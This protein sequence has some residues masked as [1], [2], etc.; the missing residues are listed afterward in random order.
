MYEEFEKK[1]KPEAAPAKSEPAPVK[2]DKAGK[3]NEDDELKIPGDEEFAKMTPKQ[4]ARWVM[5][6]VKNL[7]GKTYDARSQ[8]RDSVAQEIRDAQK[9]HPLLK[10]SS[11]YRELVLA[12][13]ESASQKGAVLSLKEACEKVDAF[14]GK[15]QGDEKV[16]DDDKI[17]LKKAKAQVERGAGAPASPGE[18]KDSEDRRLESIFGTG[19]AKSPL[20][21][22]GI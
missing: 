9:D 10:A 20:G 8:M 5:D 16:S 4:F 11:E 1:Q 7:V 18:D 2:E 3:E 15:G 6:N 19:G 22:L 17:R 14:A 12:L 21:G 13:I